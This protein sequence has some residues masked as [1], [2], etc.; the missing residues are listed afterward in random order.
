MKSENSKKILVVTG[1]YPPERCGAGDYTFNLFQAEEAKDWLLFYNKDWSLGTFSQKVKD[2]KSFNPDIINIQYPT[3]GYGMSVLPHLLSLYFRLFSRKKTVITLHENSQLGWKAKLAS[4]IFLV[5]ANKLIF[6][7][8]FEL[9]YA[10]KHYPFAGK[11]STVIKIFSNIC[12]ASELPPTGKREYDLGYFGYIRLKKG[13][14]EFI[15][16]VQELK[17]ENPSLKVYIMGQI[18]PEYQDYYNSIIGTSDEKDSIE[19]LLNKDADEV[20]SILA[21]TKLM[22]LPFPDGVSERRGSFLAAIKNLCL[23]LTTKGIFTTEAHDDICYYTNKDEAKN[24]ITEILSLP[25]NEQIEKQ[26]KISDFL[27]KEIPQSWSEVAKS[28]NQFLLS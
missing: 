21:N 23:I 12:A 8:R 15:P 14:E 10:R 18:Q 27:K 13:L 20:A 16:A 19:L 7:N 3:M 17:K 4:Y 5:F 6:T 26:N 9:D 1:T 22:Y 28:Y 24:K 2:I 25:A 11:K